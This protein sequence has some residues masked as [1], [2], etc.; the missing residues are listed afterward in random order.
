MARATTL[1]I[2][3]QAP[4]T[5][6]PSRSNH[7]DQIVHDAILLMNEA[8]TALMQLRIFDCERTSA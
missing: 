7:G 2:E 3:A 5:Q 6:L 8:D 4:R 1:T